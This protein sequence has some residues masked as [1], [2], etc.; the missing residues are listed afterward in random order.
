[1][2]FQLASR[3]GLAR[4]SKPANWEDTSPL[5]IGIPRDPTTSPTESPRKRG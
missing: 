4:E 3:R 2:N 5:E 1:M